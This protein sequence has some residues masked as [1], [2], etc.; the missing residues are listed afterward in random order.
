MAKINNRVSHENDENITKS[1]YYGIN[2]L[3][4][5]LNEYQNSFKKNILPYVSEYFFSTVSLG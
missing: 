2:E 3:N 5:K 1:L 4:D